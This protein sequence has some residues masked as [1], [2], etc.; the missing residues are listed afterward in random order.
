LFE[1]AKVTLLQAIG[2]DS[3]NGRIYALLG[4]IYMELTDFDRALATFEQAYSLNPNDPTILVLYGEQLPF[5][6]RAKEG[7]EMMNRAFRLNPRYPDWYNDMIDPFYATGQYEQVITMT[8]RKKGQA[9]LW[10]QMVLAFSYG[11]LRRQTE[12]AAA[13]S[14]LLRR[15]P[16]FSLERTL[17]DFGGTKDERTLAHYLDGARKA[18]LRDCASAEELQNYPKMAHL[19]V[20]DGKR[21]T[22]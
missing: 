7:V 13:A 20:C 21:A 2:L 6:G 22:N 18:G 5:L 14:E 4:M 9:P 16:D 8:R 3:A 1:K 12:A 17:S 15:Y 10:S 19:A 11:Q